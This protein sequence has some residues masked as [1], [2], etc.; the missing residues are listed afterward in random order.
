MCIALVSTSHPD[1][2]LIVLDNRDEYVL[3]PTSRPKWWTHQDS[4]NQVL[5]SRD[6]QRRERGTWMGVTKSGRLAVLTNFRE[7]I[8]DTVHPV[9]GI[10]SRG[11][12]VTAWLGAPN[13][14][15]LDQFV[16][17]M[18]EGGLVKG[19]GGF[20]LICGDLKPKRSK[21]ELNGN[22]VQDRE[23]EPLVIISNRS[24]AVDGV[25]RIGG[26]RGGVWGLSN[27]VYEEPATWPK[28]KL[29]RQLLKEAIEKAVASEASE[30]ELSELLF[31]VLDHDTLPPIARRAKMDFDERLDSLK[32]SIFIPAITDED[33][34]RDMLYAMEQGKMKAAFNEIEDED[35]ELLEASR[36]DDGTLFDK[37]A[38]GTQ[39]QTMILVDWDGNVTYKERALFDDHGNPV[40]HGKG[41]VAFKYT[42]DGWN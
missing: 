7:T 24:E 19:V 15:S 9:H 42:I 14:E 37:G 16:A 28:V 12:M 27:T 36:H 33:K 30:D 4:G 17:K 31:S 41:D 13:D 40:E 11:G 22:W 8:D 3:R 29:G 34:D 25:P 20:S 6:L 26:K 5:S 32:Q 2:A 21:E 10:R 1:Y 39:R 38:Y 35:H 23:V 18:L